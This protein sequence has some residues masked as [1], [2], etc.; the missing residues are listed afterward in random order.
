MKAD[1]KA[2]GESAIKEKQFAEAVDSFKQALAVDPTDDKFAKL[3]ESTEQMKVDYEAEQAADAEQRKQLAEKLAAKKAKAEEAFA[4][5]E[6]AS[7]IDLYKACVLLDPEDHAL[8]H[9]LQVSKERLHKEEE[10][11]KRAAQE[12]IDR[13]HAEEVGAAALIEE[14]MTAF[15][16]RGEKATQDGDFVKAMALF[17]MGMKVDPQSKGSTMKKLR[18]GLKKAKTKVDGQNLAAAKRY[19]KE[20]Q[21]AL[22][23][24]DSTTALK[25]FAA[26]SQIVIKD[27][28]LIEQIKEGLTAAQQ[29][30]SQ[31]TE[32]RGEAAEKNAAG[33]QAYEAEDYAGAEAAYQRGVDT[34]SSGIVLKNADDEKLL[35]EL[36]AGLQRAQ[37]AGGAYRC[38]MEGIALVEEGKVSPALKKCQ[39]GAALAAKAENQK[40]IDQLDEEMDIVKKSADMEKDKAKELGVQAMENKKYQEAMGHFEEGL[41]FAPDDEYLQRSLQHATAKRDETQAAAVKKCFDAA[42]EANAAGNIAAAIAAYI[43]GYEIETVDQSLTDSMA[44]KLRE[45][46]EEG[47][48]AFTSHR[49]HKTVSA[50]RALSEWKGI[51]KESTATIQKD[52]TASKSAYDT[53]IRQKKY[54]RA[55]NAAILAIELNEDNAA[56]LA[57]VTGEQPAM[58]AAGEELAA[59][60]EFQEAVG[61]YKLAQMGKEDEAVAAVLQDLEIKLSAFKSHEAAALVQRIAR[62]QSLIKAGQYTE[63]LVITREALGSSHFDSANKT[64]LMSEYEGIKRACLRLMT[65]RKFLSA[66]EAYTLAKELDADDSGFVKEVQTQAKNRLCGAGDKICPVGDKLAAAEN[67][68]EAVAAY[69]LAA[70]VEHPDK[71]LSKQLQLTIKKTTTKAKADLKKLGLEAKA[72]FKQ[73][74]YETAAQKY[75]AGIRLDIIDSSKI[76]K[77]AELSEAKTLF[78]SHLADEQYE[79]ALGAYTYV[80]S[81]APGDYTFRSTSMRAVAE[82][83]VGA[84]AEPLLAAEQHYEAVAALQLSLTFT[85]DDQLKATLSTAQEAL[86]AYEV[87]KRENLSDAVEECVAISMGQDYVT[88]FAKYKAVVDHKLCNLKISSLF[89]DTKTA[90]ALTA[91]VEGFEDLFDQEDYWGAWHAFQLVLAAEGGDVAFMKKAEGVVYPVRTDRTKKAKPDAKSIGDAM[92]K[93]EKFK[94]AKGAYSLALHFKP[95]DKQLVLGVKKAD[96]KLDAEDKDEATKLAEALPS[97]LAAFDEGNYSVAQDTIVPLAGNRFCNPEDMS[98]MREKVAPAK[99][100]FQTAFAAEK[101]SNAHAAYIIATAV[102]PDGDEFVAKAKATCGEMAFVA[103]KLMFEQKLLAEAV[104]AYRLAVVGKPADL[105]LRDKLKDAIEALDSEA[106]AAERAAAEAEKAKKDR[107]TEKIFQAQNLVNSSDYNTAMD[108]YLELSP[109]DQAD[110]L[111]QEVVASVKLKYW[112]HFKAG[113]YLKAHDAY[114]FATTLSYGLEDNFDVQAKEQMASMPDTAAKCLEAKDWEKAVG[115]YRLALV[116]QP[117]DEELKEGLAIA[118][119]PHNEELD[120]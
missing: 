1:L 109:E 24:D 81:I 117:A 54:H 13:K 114:T 120:D 60:D 88:A 97:A 52:L 14:K 118:E 30:A 111:V 82:A 89:A 31:E 85:Q 64:A 6:W 65:D 28:D 59:A 10:D 35:A 96:K 100:L 87:V 17:T 84:K 71:K 86:S 113:E 68:A 33:Q 83:E 107:I 37:D 116:L 80:N 19:H 47:H 93:Q 11:A 3:V 22:K 61:A 32:C 4:K 103:E 18:H 106:N 94:D 16:E 27:Q 77:P 15:T 72:P 79:R 67:F 66:Y 55:C 29:G 112:E 98:A 62:A 104:P 63:P 105:E 57:A 38:L 39:E 74:E 5:N 12:E 23:A 9:Q 119:A 69:S 40:L 108:I 26:A 42:N 73:R 76:G 43:E 92:T 78:A 2:K 99:E 21:D 41:L 56:A 91:A 110:E 45:F 70:L 46:V 50:Y 25:S 75:F 102:E 7:A 34:L 101:F 51:D 36:S 90:P 115:A 95:D 8:S 48:K 20:A 58:V 49:F 53:A 44:D